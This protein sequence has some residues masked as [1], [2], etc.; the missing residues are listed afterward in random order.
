[1]ASESMPNIEL[2]KK[3]FLD[4][5]K[6]FKCKLCSELPST[7]VKKFYRCFNQHLICQTCFQAKKPCCTQLSLFCNRCGKGNHIIHLYCD[8]YREFSLPILGCQENYKECTLVKE[9]LDQWK[10]FA[11]IYYKNGCREIDTHDKLLE[12]QEE[13]TFREIQCPDIKCLKKIPF[14]TFSDHLFDP[15]HIQFDNPLRSFQQME[16][17]QKVKLV[18]PIPINK[19]TTT[20]KLLALSGLTFIEMWYSKDNTMYNW[21]YLLG[22]PYEAQRFQYHVHFGKEFGKETTFYGKVKSINVSYKDLLL[23]EN[24]CIT[25]I[26]MMKRYLNE[27]GQLEYTLKIRNLKEEV[28]DDNCESGINDSD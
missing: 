6:Q 22:D 4:L 20:P 21:V 23:D 10:L 15:G 14:S 25:S 8:T 3:L 5:I 24:T 27:Q 2:K 19:S 9:I 17:G 12:H 7:R 26:Q 28:K 16:F 11:C 18:R 1:M 13:C